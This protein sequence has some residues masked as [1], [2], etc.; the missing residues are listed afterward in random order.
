MEQRERATDVAAGIPA[1]RRAGLP[2]P[3]EKTSRIVKRL[4]EL[5]PPLAIMPIPGGK[6]ATLYVRQGCL[7]LRLRRHHHRL[8][9]LQLDVQLTQLLRLDASG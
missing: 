3:A 9:N 4:D 7:T 1:C 8:F 5:Q 2:S 6:D